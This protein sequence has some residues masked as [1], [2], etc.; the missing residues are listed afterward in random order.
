[1]TLAASSWT[2]R[3]G[4]HALLLLAPVLAFA[5]LAV[6]ADVRAWLRRRELRLEP[7][8]VLA[9]IFSIGAAAV[10]VAV[11]PEHYQEHLLYGVFFT[12]AASAQLGWAALLLASGRRWLLEVGALANTAMLA[13]WLVSRTTG[14]PFGPG[15]GEVETVGRFDIIATSCEVGLIACCLYALFRAPGLNATRQAG[16]GRS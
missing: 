8:H 10:H 7:A 4:V 16:Y 13:L 14:L 6:V 3:H 9:A 5:G 12:I 15:A 2:A 1:M 11:C